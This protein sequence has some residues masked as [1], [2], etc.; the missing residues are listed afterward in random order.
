M[1]RN[2]LH[3]VEVAIDRTHTWAVTSSGADAAVVSVLKLTRRQG[4]AGAFMVGSRLAWH[5]RVG[6]A[7]ADGRL[8]PK[9]ML[10]LALLAPTSTGDS[11]LAGSLGV[12]GSLDSRRWGSPLVGCSMSRSEARTV[13]RCALLSAGRSSFLYPLSPSCFPR[14]TSAI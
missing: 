6:C 11:A 5:A 1:R 2:L 9:A 8:H 12:C 7:D 10:T 13:S 4:R 14:S 3:E